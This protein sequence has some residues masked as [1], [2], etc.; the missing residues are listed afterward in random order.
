MK[1]FYLIFFL[2]SFF[3]LICFLLIVF[4]YKRNIIFKNKNFCCNKNLKF[5][6]LIFEFIIVSMFLNI[7]YSLIINILI[8]YFLWTLT[9]SRKQKNKKIIDKQILE[10]IRLFRNYVSAGQSFAQTIESVSKQIKEPLSSEFKEISNKVNLGISL[11]KALKSSALNVS[12]EQ[13]KFFT[14]ALIISHS[15]GIKISDI[16]LKIEESLNKKTDLASKIDVLTSQVRFSGNVVSFIPF[17]IVFLVYFFEQ[18][19][20]STLFTTLIG[21]FVL[22][23]S[24]IMI[25]TGTFIMKKISD[26]KL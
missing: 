19:M 12:N 4:K 18:D 5:I 14:D 23:I 22:L 13:Y 2:L 26:I 10:T 6:L 7:I 25:L 24:V 21:N 17:V 9:V 11:E 20:I 3:G 15:T 8:L 1:I 16:L